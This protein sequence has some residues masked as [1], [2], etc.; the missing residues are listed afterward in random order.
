[1]A[2]VGQSRFFR[3]GGGSRRARYSAQAVN[4]NVS[5]V[6]NSLS[7]TRNAFIERGDKLD[8]L[9]EKTNALNNASEEFAKMAKELADSQEKGIFGW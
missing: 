9:V 5:G 7:Q 8:N 1:M 3:R 2:S 6:M 4:Y